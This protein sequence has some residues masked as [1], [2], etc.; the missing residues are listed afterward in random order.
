MGCSRSTDKRLTPP[1]ARLVTSAAKA[2]TVGTS[3]AWRT[4]ESSWT[5]VPHSAETTRPSHPRHSTLHAILEALPAGNWATYGSLADAV[6]TAPQPLGG[7][8]TTCTQCANAH[9]ILANQ[10]RI[11]QGFAWTDPTDQR[12]PRD[13]LLAEG[14]T[15][16]ESKADPSQELSSDALAGLI[17]Q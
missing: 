9:R 13:V 17:A 3:G 10:G 2:P 14:V 16:I 12:D 8:I 15:F 5:C 6:G 4:A 7:H 1:P 11:A